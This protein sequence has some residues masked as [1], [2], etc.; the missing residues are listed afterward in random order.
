MT[1][2]KILVCIVIIAFCVFLGYVASG[3]YRARKKFFMQL[4]A[5]NDRYLN[6]LSYARK[7]LGEFLQAYPY[8]GD[9]QKA[10]SSFSEKRE[11]QIK[12]GYLSKEEKKEFGDYLKMLGTGDSASQKSFFAAQKPGIEEKRAESEKQ[13]KVRCELYLK[14]GLLAGLAFVILIV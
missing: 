10:L 2:L 11:T 5:F 12:F 13:A 8:T 3:K 6:E 14:L 7:P 9:F 4:S 1:W